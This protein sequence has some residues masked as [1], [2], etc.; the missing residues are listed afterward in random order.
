MMKKRKLPFSLFTSKDI[1]DAV[2]RLERIAGPVILVKG[3][4]GYLAFGVHAVYSIIQERAKA[5][6]RK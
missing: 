5:V 6:K 2:R 1:K 3:N 4:P